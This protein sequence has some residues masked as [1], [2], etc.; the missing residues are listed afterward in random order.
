MWPHVGKNYKIKTFK[1][2][3]KKNKIICSPI[4]TTFV[5]NKSQT[6]VYLPQKFPI[7][8]KKINIDYDSQ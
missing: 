4:S 3:A 8:I 2:K 7:K 1:R 5:Q 6:I